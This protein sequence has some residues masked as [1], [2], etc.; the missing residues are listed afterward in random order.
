[1]LYVCP[2]FKNSMLGFVLG[3]IYFIR[4]VSPENQITGLLLFLVLVPLLL[5]PL[6]KR[7]QIT[8]SISIVAL[9]LWLLLGVI[10]EGIGA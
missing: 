4:D 3:P 2:E 1:M 9:I 5:L 7:N 8:I 6:V 10:G